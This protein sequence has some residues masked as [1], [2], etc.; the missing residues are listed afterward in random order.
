MDDYEGMP[1]MS[2][3]IKEDKAEDRCPVPDTESDSSDSDSEAG[4]AVLQ[5][6]VAGGVV[7]SRYGDEDSDVASL[8]EPSH[9]HKKRKAGGVAGQ[10]KDLASRSGLRVVAGICTTPRRP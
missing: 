6:R 10:A 1:G 8:R 7:S 9:A 3:E 4:E 5:G 2:P